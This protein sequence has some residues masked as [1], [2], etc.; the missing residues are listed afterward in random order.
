MGSKVIE[1]VMPCSLS[2]AL[3]TD[4]LL[5]HRVFSVVVLCQ[6][7]SSEYKFGEKIT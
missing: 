2:V 4:P 5:C 1:V 3:G 7:Y 6:P